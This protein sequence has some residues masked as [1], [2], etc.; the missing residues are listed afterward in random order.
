[1][2][3]EIDK[4]DVRLIVHYS[5]PK[6][7][8]GYYQE[9]GRAGRDGEK[10]ECVLFYSYG[11]T[12]KQNYF[13]REIRDSQVRLSAQNKLREMVD[14]CELKSCR[15]DYLLKYFGEDLK[16]ECKGCDCCLGSEELVLKAVKNKKQKGVMTSSD[17][18]FEKLRALRKAIA[19]KNGVPPYIVFNDASLRE[20]VA[21]RPSNEAEFLK[22]NGVGREKLK[23]YGADFLKAM[24]T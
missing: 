13:I 9:T 19:I 24:A 3:W 6:S 4:S 14:Y 17:P 22:I 21:E 1:M 15:R 18:L 12:A 11:D 16:E 23:R 7:I 10:S 8:E 2:A 5:L 20:M